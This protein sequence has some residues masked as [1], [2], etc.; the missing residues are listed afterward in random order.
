[1]AFDYSKLLGLMRE[2]QITQNELAVQIGNTLATLNLKLNNKAKFKQSEIVQI[3]E[4]LGIEGD[5][6]GTYFFT[7]KV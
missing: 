3:C 2:K 1:M 5:D 7:A 6:I 4:I